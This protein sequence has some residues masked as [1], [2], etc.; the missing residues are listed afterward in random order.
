LPRSEIR[1]NGDIGIYGE[2]NAG[3]EIVENEIAGNPEAGI[4]MSGSRM[5]FV[6]NRLDKNGDGIATGGSHSTIRNNVITRSQ[7]CGVHCGLGIQ[8][9]AGSGNRIVGNLVADVETAGI[10][11][12]GYGPLSH[13]LVAHNTVRGAGEDAFRVKSVF[14]PVSHVTLR[15]NQALG[16]RSDGFDVSVDLTRL[17][18]NEANGNGDLGI[19][20]ASGVTDAGGNR[21][22]GNG[23]A[24][25]CVNV[26]C[27]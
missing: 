8:V 26:H 22:A 13:V 7:R 3:S 6:R 11:V 5:L 9:E 12:A 23:D 18:D 19:E 25:Q 24:R 27:G 10:S 14:E 15:H 17:H 1:D 20:A 16:A 21:A 2:E 4:L